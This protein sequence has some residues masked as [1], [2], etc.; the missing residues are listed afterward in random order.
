MFLKS[1]FGNSKKPASLNQLHLHLHRN[2]S[3]REGDRGR[4]SRGP[5]LSTSERQALH[6]AQKAMQKDE[7]WA[8]SSSK[9]TMVS[10][11]NGFLQYKFHM[12]VVHQLASG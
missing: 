1:R 2:A 5:R 7:A 10:V 9:P 12:P 8:M 4:N 11:E 3:R 6:V